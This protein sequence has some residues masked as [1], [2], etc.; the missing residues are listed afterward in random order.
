[1]AKNYNNLI[2]DL[3]A[4]LKTFMPHIRRV[5]AINAVLIVY[6][7]SPSFLSFVAIIVAISA[8]AFDNPT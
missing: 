5:L 6:F 2:I 4:D 3:M 1:M 7:L 8:I